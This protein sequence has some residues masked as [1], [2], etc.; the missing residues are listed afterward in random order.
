[1]PKAKNEQQMETPGH[2]QLNNDSGYERIL[3]PLQNEDNTLN[4]MLETNNMDDDDEDGSSW[5]NEDE[6][7]DD[8]QSD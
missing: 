7:Y 6:D 3:A 5:A 2:Q 1:M 8:D 4:K